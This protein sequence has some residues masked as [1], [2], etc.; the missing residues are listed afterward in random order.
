MSRFLAGGHWEPRYQLGHVPSVT[1]VLFSLAT[2]GTFAGGTA[3]TCKLFLGPQIIKFSGYRGPSDE[4]SG[5][6]N[7]QGNGADVRDAL[8]DAANDILIHDA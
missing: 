6:G 7:T 8:G 5:C 1:A 4:R 2:G 3:I